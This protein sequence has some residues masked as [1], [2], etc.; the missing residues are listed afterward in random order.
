ML[1][2]EVFDDADVWRVPDMDMPEFVP[3]REIEEFVAE[4]DGGR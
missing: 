3:E 2:V 4:E 1:I